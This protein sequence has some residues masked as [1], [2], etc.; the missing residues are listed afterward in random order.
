M[1]PRTDFL[2]ILRD[3]SSTFPVV[4]VRIFP[5]AIWS[6]VTGFYDLVTLEVPGFTAAFSLNTIDLGWTVR[7]LRFNS[8][9]APIRNGRLRQLRM[10]CTR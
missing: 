2:V 5:Q 6:N 10:S 9:P 1:D 8:F 3:N 4:F 7:R